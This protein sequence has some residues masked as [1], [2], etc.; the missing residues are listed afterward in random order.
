MK[1]L[2]TSYAVTGT[3]LLNQ[4]RSPII[5]V[6]SLVGP[7][8]VGPCDPLLLDASASS[9]SGGRK[10]HFTYTVQGSGD[11]DVVANL[12]VLLNNVSSEQFWVLL[13][14]G[15]LEQGQSYQFTLSVVNFR[16]AA[17]SS[18]ITVR[19]TSVPVP[20]LSIFGADQVSLTTYPVNGEVLLRRRITYLC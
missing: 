13:E 4:P 19:A 7:T 17:A 16:G 5:P 11:Q 20:L 14:P 1:T 2:G 9:G 12:R 8:A 18:T 10:M 6:A 15:T 3:V